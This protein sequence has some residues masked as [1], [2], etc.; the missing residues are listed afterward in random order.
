MRR[1]LKNRY[2]IGVFCIAL[3]AAVAYYIIPRQQLLDP[4]PISVLRLRENTP[5]NNEFDPTG[6]V[7][8]VEYA[9]ILTR[10]YNAAL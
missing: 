6:F 7:T 5:S 1:I 4:E 9:T 3:A 10:L 2:V 8:R